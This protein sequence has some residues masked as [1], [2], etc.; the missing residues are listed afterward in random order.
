[1]KK[2]KLLIWCEVMCGRC[3]NLAHGEYYRGHDT[4]KRCDIA[5]KNWIDDDVIYGNLCPE[6]Q[7]QI[8]T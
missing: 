3:G 7:K 8:N 1:M 5:S 6:C 4:I 2:R